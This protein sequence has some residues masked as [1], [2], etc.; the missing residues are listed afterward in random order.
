[1]DCVCDD[2][3]V[4]SDEG[5]CI[6]SQFCASKCKKNEVFKLCPTACLIHCGNINNSHHSCIEDTRDDHDCVADCVCRQGLIRDFVTNS[7]VAREN[8][9]FLHSS[10]VDPYP[11]PPN[12]HFEEIGPTFEKYCHQP[13]SSVQTALPLP[14]SQTRNTRSGCFCNENYVRLGPNAICIPENECHI[15]LR[16]AN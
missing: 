2:G 5:D 6:L 10:T 1:M 8:C 12:E 14:S 11:C 13:P 3:Y 7:C 15:M 9:T 4:K 16:Y